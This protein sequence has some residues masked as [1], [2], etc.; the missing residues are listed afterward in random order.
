MTVVGARFAA[1]TGGMPRAS[2]LPIPG[3]RWDAVSLAALVFGGFGSA[4]LPPLMTI[5]GMSV[6]ASLPVLVVLVV[7]FALRCWVRGSAPM[8]PY[9]GSLAL[10]W[11]PFFAWTL[12][13]ADDI[14]RALGQATLLG[15]DIA[16]YI[17][18]V[19]L[20]PPRRA[21]S[22][23]VVTLLGWATVIGAAWM[24][25]VTAGGRLGWPFFRDQFFGEELAVYSSNGL[26][27]VVVPRFI[28]GVIVGSF[29]GPLT[30]LFL[31]LATAKNGKGRRR[32][33]MF[34][35]A[36]FVGLVLAI[37]RGS[38]LGLLVALAVALGL[39]LREP[40][41]AARLAAVLGVLLVA[42]TLGTAVFPGGSDAVAATL[43]RATELTSVGSYETGTVAAR[44]TSWGAMLNDV[45]SDPLVGQGALA[46]RRYFPPELTASEN[47]PLEILH[48][49]GVLGFVGLMS[50]Q[51]R[52]ILGG[53]RCALKQ[54]PGGGR[55]L[56]AGLTATCTAMLVVSVTNP[57]AW[58]PLYWILFALLVC[59]TNGAK[60]SSRAQ[61]SAA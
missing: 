56:V 41:A 6:R 29:L 46:F 47:F 26:A 20:L 3:F 18:V 9:F 14:V 61:V 54:A 57:F 16:H 38:I 43:G 55:D 48:S 30:V 23:R 28:Y 52:A 8:V 13:R 1:S 32:C 7:G 24:V 36:S 15:L 33:A 2:T 19:W 5:G 40:R 25:A 34:A 50:F 59:S 51:L 49:A 27:S 42:G 53:V 37:S 4:W 44:L 60:A 17:V 12:L 39:R 58:S 10:M 31:T 35:G 45:V 21:Q 22:T 11:L